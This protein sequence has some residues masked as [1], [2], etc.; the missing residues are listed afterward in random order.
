M[1]IPDEKIDEVDKMFRVVYTY[2]DDAKQANASATETL[3]RIAEMLDTEHTKTSAKH[4]KKV[5][6]K[7]YKDWVDKNSGD[8]SSDDASVVV[9]QLALREG[10][11]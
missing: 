10:A 1:I 3:N 4:W 7:A 5:A 8:N 6:K 2:K 9:T 11:E